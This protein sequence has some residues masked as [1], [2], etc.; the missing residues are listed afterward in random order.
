MVHLAQPTRSI[1]TGSSA[2]VYNKGRT[3]IILPG[4]P[5]LIKADVLVPSQLRQP[6]TR[7]DQ[8]ID[9]DGESEHV[10]VTRDEGPPR[11]DSTNEL[12]LSPT[13]VTLMV[14]HSII[15]WVLFYRTALDPQR[16][17][18]ALAHVLSHYPVLTGRVVGTK[19]DLRRDPQATGKV[20]LNNTG[21]LLT[22]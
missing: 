13:D 15:P 10:L 1:W 11:C 21:A 7:K 16:L 9:E 19:N 17:E 2:V 12:E 20:K 8:V 4:Y 22:L 5:K 18:K 6:D 3:N 14:R